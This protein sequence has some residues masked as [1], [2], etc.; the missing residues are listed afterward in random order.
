M[1]RTWGYGTVDASS[2]S[3]VAAYQF[4]SLS[5]FVITDWRA[6]GPENQGSVAAGLAML[7]VHD[8]L[9]PMR[10]APNPAQMDKIL[11]KTLA[12]LD[13]AEDRYEATLRCGLGV[14]VVD[15][16]SAVFG[17]HGS[18]AAYRVRGEKVARLKSGRV[19]ALQPADVI[20]LAVDV[21][22]S[23][24]LAG[25]DWTLPHRAVRQWLEGC[26][27]TDGAMVAVSMGMSP[28]FIPST[29]PPPKTE[30]LGALRSGMRVQAS[31]GA[32]RGGGEVVPTWG[33]GRLLEE[34]EETLER[35]KLDYQEADEEEDEEGEELPWKQRMILAFEETLEWF[36]DYIKTPGGQK[37]LAAIALVLVVTLGGLV[38]LNMGEEEA[39][40][41]AW[42][43]VAEVVVG[44]DGRAEFSTNRKNAPPQQAD[45]QAEL[46]GRAAP[47]A[48]DGAKAEGE[49]ELVPEERSPVRWS[50]VFVFGLIVLG[51]LA[52]RRRV[53]AKREDAM[54]QVKRLKLEGALK[55]RRCSVVA[56]GADGQRGIGLSWDGDT[57][58]WG[59]SGGERKSKDKKRIIGVRDPTLLQVRMSELVGARVLV[60]QEV[61]AKGKGGYKQ[62]RLTRLDLL[63]LS[64]DL[65]NATHR[66]RLVDKPVVV[67]SEEHRTALAVARHWEGVALAVLHDLE[68]PAMDGGW[69]E[70][71]EMDRGVMGL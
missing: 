60:D 20:A 35:E 67:G 37:R 27:S 43:E 30:L 7:A 45:G 14:V 16:G 49:D 23:S 3:A 4:D 68:R 53:A 21:G 64:S 28:E 39:V 2:K 71:M 10:V 18:V 38:K 17:M 61:V 36:E 62:T 63:F 51:V 50:P 25:S 32:T 69:E 56:V 26:G 9:R 33:R 48:A 42:S 46:P 58:W 5:V 66:L 44:P 11:A 12:L 54:T 6:Q 70:P 40:V 22:S 1:I 29:P 15:E 47:A 52:Y 34:E 41:D 8:L 55:K 65:R 57:M 59:T 13:K 19:P 31:S 24:G